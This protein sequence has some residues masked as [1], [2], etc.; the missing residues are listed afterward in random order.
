M[1]DAIRHVTIAAMRRDG[2]VARARERPLPVAI[3]VGRA[4]VPSIVA[5]NM[6][7]GKRWSNVPNKYERV[8]GSWALNRLREESLVAYGVE[9][10][11]TAVRCRGSPE[12]SAHRRRRAG[13][14]HLSREMGQTE[15]AGA[16]YPRLVR[17]ICISA[18]ISGS[19]R[20]DSN[21][22][23][24][25][26][27]TDCVPSTAVRRCPACPQPRGFPP[28]RVQRRAGS[29]IA[30]RVLVR[31]GFQSISEPSPICRTPRSMSRI[32]L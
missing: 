31:V 14:S 16:T 18:R 28:G 4:H 9:M 25:V 2:E 19:R 7:R 26:Y 23:P 32:L 20:G 24:A 15:K 11:P 27:K 12:M 17:R 22:E 13:R 30:V 8:I 3:P 10:A 21:S 6:K 5:A 29:S 1:A